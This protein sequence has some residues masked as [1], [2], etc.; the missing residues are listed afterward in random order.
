VVWKLGLL[1]SELLYQ[2]ITMES[3]YLN[4]VLRDIEALGCKIGSLQG[5]LAAKHVNIKLDHYLQLECVK[6]HFAELRTRIQEIDHGDLISVHEQHAIELC[7]QRLTE[8][9]DALLEAL[10]RPTHALTAKRFTSIP[11][12]L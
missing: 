7:R 12:R 2:I 9:V 4:Q 6:G 8:A 10:S 3:T 1:A 11:V 5:Y